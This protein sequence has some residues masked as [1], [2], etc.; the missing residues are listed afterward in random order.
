MKPLLLGSVLP[1]VPL[2]LLT[3]GYFVY[4]R[5]FDPFRPGEFIFDR[6]YDALYFGDP[7]WI[8]GHNLLHSPPILVGLFGVAYLAAQRER[9]WASWLGW[10]TA[11]CAFHSV[12]DIV[13]HHDDGPLLFF[14]FDWSL[15][16]SS[17]I[18]YWDRDHYAAIVSPVEHTADLLIIG[19]FVAFFAREAWERRR[20]RL[21]AAVD[22]AAGT[23]A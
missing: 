21:I 2:F 4:R 12:L 23:D 3:V 6:R 10:F 8:A 9:A 16:F 22:D 15:R 14:P 18:S 5:L 19:Y 7:F 13:S 11:G 1:D 20:G 17:P